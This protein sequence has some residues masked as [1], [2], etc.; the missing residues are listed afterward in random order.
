MKHVQSKGER[1][2]QMIEAIVRRFGPLSRVQVYELTHLRRTTISNL[3]RALLR[4]RRLVEAGPADNPTGRKQTLLQLNGNY[5]SVVAL[6]FDEETIAAGVLD[7]QLRVRETRK[8]RAN[9]EGGQ[10]GLLNQLAACIHKVVRKSKASGQ[11]LLGIGIADPGLVDSRRG[12]TT[13]SST[14]EFWKH[15]PL[16]QA[17]EAEFK[18]P[19]LVESKTRAKAVAE[20]ML[21]AGG[22][23][24]NLIY[25]DYGVGIGA[26][27]IVDGRLLYGQECAVGEFGHTHV[28][29]GGPACKCGSIGCLEAI[30]GTGAV[31]A[32]IR[33][34]LAEG[35][36]SQVLAM[37]EGK[38]ANVT[39]WMVLQAAKAGDKICS[40]IV[41]EVANH[42]GLGVSNLV[43]LF[44]P[45]V[46]VLDKRLEMAGDLL[47]DQVMQVV[48]RQA[49]SNAVEG[50]SLTFGKLDN[51]PGLLGMGLMV[52]DKYFEIPAFRP[53]RFMIEPVH[54]APASPA[55][56]PLPA[57]AFRRR[58][59]SSRRLERT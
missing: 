44:N 59:E 36:H 32:K 37:A 21:G 7:L 48:K 14:I 19:I 8:E 31:V 4:E 40:N 58:T 33:K 43:N 56:Q 10:E 27:I 13:T 29:E 34:A 45:G 46:V 16:R 22:K 2:K 30:A 1:D 9:L 5:G 42:L 39:A 47:L 23:C 17:L 20:R 49:L 11:P 50:L 51:E 52:L 12:I 25:V 15:V 35:A 53:P 18:V 41:T 57:P 6:E 3:V 54:L 55:A 28:T 38:E 26:G 24:D